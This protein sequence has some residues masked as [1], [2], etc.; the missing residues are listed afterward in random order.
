MPENVFPYPGGK[1]LL[2]PWIIKHLPDHHT[3]VEVFGGSGAVLANKPESPVE[4]FN[5]RDGDIVQ[6]FQVLRDREDELREWLSNTPFAYDLHRKY[7]H[8]FFSGYRPDDAVERA[9]RFFYLRYSQFAR[10]HTAYSGFRY[11]TQEDTASEL[12][13]A[14]H[15]LE[16]FAER[17]RRVQL[18]NR[19]Y[20]EVFAKHDGP[21][22]VFYCDPPYVKEGDALYS[23][24]SFDH[25]RFVDQLNQLEAR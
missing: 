5:D 10:K 16:A 7:A 22:T 17:F 11:S 19:D 2:A 25:G 8:Q 20:S 21:D 9:G 13:H 14:T 6:F 24:S 3:Y 12:R 4:V 1:T 15:D 23:H 18:E